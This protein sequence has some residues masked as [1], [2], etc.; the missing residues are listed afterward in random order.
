MQIVQPS[1]WG[2]ADYVYNAETGIERFKTTY[3]F[4]LCG[5]PLLPTGTCLVKKKRKYWWAEPRKGEKLPLDWEQGL[6]VW[7]VVAVHADGVGMGDKL[8]AA[9]FLLS[10]SA[11]S[12][13]ARSKRVRLII[14]ISFRSISMWNWGHVQERKARECG[15]TIVSPEEVS[16]TE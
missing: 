13:A 11:H 10:S 8:V 6:K 12:R 3:F 16:N 9:I 5:L 15:A 14:F 1:R 2:K 4:T 7:I